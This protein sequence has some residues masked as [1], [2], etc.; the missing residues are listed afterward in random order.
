MQKLYWRPARIEKSAHLLVAVI[1]V[2]GLVAV[3]RFERTLVQ[4]H[5]EQKLAAARLMQAGMELLREHRVR[6][7]GPVDLEVDPTHSGMVGLASSPVTT[8]TG[9]LE[10]K[11]TSTNPNWAAAVVDLLHEADVQPGDTIAVGF[12]GS[13]PALNLA[14]LC[15]AEVLELEV[16]SI[17][18]VGA[19]SWGANVPGFTWLDMES[20][21]NQ[22]GIVSTRSIA[23][24]LGGTRDRAVGMGAAGRRRL[25]AVVRDAGIEF[26]ETEEDVESIDRRM[27]LYRLHAPGPI[28]AYVNVG[29]SLVSIGPKPVKRVYRPGLIRRLPPRAS[30]IDSVIKRFIRGGVPV[31]N[32]SKIVPLAESYG[33]PIEPTSMPPVGRGLVFARQEVNL[34]LVGGA[35][36][37][38]TGSLYALLHRG[39]G[40][41]AGRG[42]RLEPMI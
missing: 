15:A 42:R 38:I 25:E 5:F 39:L 30:P 2:A 32:L 41:R 18:S 23:A 4:P 33:F 36:L 31:I 19:S 21:L 35:L 7:F 37:A 13:F 26:I 17:A 20:L 11:R 22:G 34:W 27:D 10:A 16:V 28:R 3:L 8:N 29:G 40:S 14:A 6:H 12:S 9:S 24:S 1:A